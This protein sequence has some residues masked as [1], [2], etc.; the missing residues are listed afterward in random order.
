[1]PVE[2]IFVFVESTTTATES[3]GT[4]SGCKQEVLKEINSAAVI[5]RM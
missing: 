4:V 3:P 5:I 1:M 2:S